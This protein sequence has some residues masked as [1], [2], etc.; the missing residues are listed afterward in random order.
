MNSES[1]VHNDVGGNK[2]VISTINIKCTTFIIREICS[3]NLQM[4][5]AAHKGSIKH[6]LKTTVLNYHNR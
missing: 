5:P 4:P 6:S 1:N 2:R 3:Q